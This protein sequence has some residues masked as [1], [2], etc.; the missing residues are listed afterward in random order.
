MFRQNSFK[1]PNAIIFFHTKFS[2][3]VNLLGWSKQKHYSL[4]IKSDYR[5]IDQVFSTIS[6]NDMKSLIVS[7]I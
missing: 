6:S 1:K 5:K 2:I 4:H 7:L 3:L